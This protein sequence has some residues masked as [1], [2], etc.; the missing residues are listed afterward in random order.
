MTDR[1]PD[2]VR[3]VLAAHVGDIRRALEDAADAI[4]G[5]DYLLRQ[6]QPDDEPE[7]L[8]FGD[9]MAPWQP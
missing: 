3:V 6:L 9:D 7:P 1:L 8:D 2:D 5:A 4:A